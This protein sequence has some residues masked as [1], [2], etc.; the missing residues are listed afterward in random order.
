MGL[1][2]SIEGDKV[3]I[4]TNIFIYAIEGFEPYENELGDLFGAI[5]NGDIQSATSELTL[6]ESL[7]KPIEEEN[8]NQQQIYKETLQDRRHFRLIPVRRPILVESA[9]LRATTSLRLPDAIHLATAHEADCDTL[10]TNDTGF[11]DSS[12]IDIIILSDVLG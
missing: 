1:L 5:D 7:V 12:H 2:K 8:V 4:D 3:Y 9:H 6:A 11:R 10:I